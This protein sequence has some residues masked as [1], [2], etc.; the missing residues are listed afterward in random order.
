MNKRLTHGDSHDELELGI[1][2]DKLREHLAAHRV[3]SVN[4]SLAFASRIPMSD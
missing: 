4:A 1:V 3:I 2:Q